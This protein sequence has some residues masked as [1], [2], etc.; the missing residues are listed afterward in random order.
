M[1]SKRKMA[2]S[3]SAVSE[4]DRGPVSKK[5]KLPVSIHQYKGRF[6]VKRKRRGGGGGGGCGCAVEGRG[7]KKLTGMVTAFR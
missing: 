1:S 7:V 2:A 3:A 5:R 4:S 6:V